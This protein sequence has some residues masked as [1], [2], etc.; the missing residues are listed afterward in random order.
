M[1]QECIRRSS[2]AASVVIS[3]SGETSSFSLLVFNMKQVIVAFT[4]A[5]RTARDYLCIYLTVGYL[6]AAYMRIFNRSKCLEIP[7]RR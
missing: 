5:V 2:H 3:V 6:K 7:N 4:L 1:C